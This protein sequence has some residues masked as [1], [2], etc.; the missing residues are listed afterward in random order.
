VH[1]NIRIIPAIV[2]QRRKLRAL[3]AKSAHLGPPLEE[4]VFHYQR[5]KKGKRTASPPR[6]LKS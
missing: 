4:H 5:L 1:T 3:V 6:E 2:A